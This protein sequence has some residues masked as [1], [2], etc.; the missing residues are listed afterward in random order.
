MEYPEDPGPAFVLPI[1]VC[2]SWISHIIGSNHL[3]KTNLGNMYENS[4]KKD[5]RSTKHPENLE[6]KN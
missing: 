6:Q 2:M 1:N 5:L 4:K 3:R